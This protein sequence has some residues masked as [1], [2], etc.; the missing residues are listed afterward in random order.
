MKEKGDLMR[1]RSGFALLVLWV[2][3]IAACLRDGVPVIG[4]DEHGNPAQVEISGKEYSKRLSAVISSVPESTLEALGES[5]TRSGWML[6]TA[7]VGIGVGAEIGIG[8]FKIGALPRARLL[9]SNSTEPA[10]P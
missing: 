7:V 8:P 10:I 2:L 6:R 3:P 1:R 4:F 9:F 5:S